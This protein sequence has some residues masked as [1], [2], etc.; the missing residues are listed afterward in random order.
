MATWRHYV[1]GRYTPTKFV[2]E[3]KKKGV[4]RRVT[5][6]IAKSMAFGD[7]VELL[8]WQHGKP[9]H[10]A[11]F[12]ITTITLPAE[13]AKEVAQQ[14]GKEYAPGSLGGEQVTRECGSYKEIGTV[15]LEPE[16]QLDMKTLVEKAIQICKEKNVA[17]WVMIGGHIKEVIEPA[18]EVLP[19]PKFS[20]GFARVESTPPT[21]LQKSTA[22]KA[23]DHYQKRRTKARHDLQIRL[24]I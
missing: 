18:Q 24:P 8:Y 1:G 17:P 12:T 19:A 20:R 21:T 23:V 6:P 4:S 15:L 13:I 14:I 7:T 10:F 16:D 9:V 5:A 11:T 2:D 22:V 3:A